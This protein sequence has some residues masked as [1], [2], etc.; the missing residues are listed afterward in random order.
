LRLGSGTTVGMVERPLMLT[1]RRPSGAEAQ[2]RR[3]SR[4]NPFGVAPAAPVLT[5]VCPDGSRDQ[6]GWPASPSHLLR[7][8]T[9][10]T[11]TGAYAPSA[12]GCSARPDHLGH[13]SQSI[14][15]DSS[16]KPPV[17]IPITAA[18]MARP[19]CGWG[20]RELRIDQIPITTAP[21]ADPNWSGKRLADEF[22][23][24]IPSRKE[25]TPSSPD[26]NPGKRFVMAAAPPWTPYLTTGSRQS[27]HR[28]LQP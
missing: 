17:T 5:A 22:A 13:S 19:R 4:L 9:R 25:S 8:K 15:A 20:L 26:S 11:L 7:C 1:R 24:H 28:P 18:P 6:R 14:P 3:S 27:V 12:P 2:P 21:I 23:P 10:A 16:K